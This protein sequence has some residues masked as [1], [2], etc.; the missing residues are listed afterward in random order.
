MSNAIDRL[1][2][3]TNLD[4]SERA[5]AR[6]RFTQWILIAI[7]A[8]LV[9]TWV[10]GVIYAYRQPMIRQVAIENERIVGE[11]ELCPGDKLLIR[12]DFEA[13]SAGKLVQDDTLWLVTPP[14]RL[15]ASTTRAFL[16]DSAMT[17]ELTEAWVIPQMYVDLATAEV[18]PL[19]AGT[20][21]RLFAISSP[22]RASVFDVGSV[23]FTIREGCAP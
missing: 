6:A 14:R 10:W 21:K 2:D 23:N 18:V 16:M 3:S 4:A 19:P 7:L 13:D 12:F 15:I 8:I 9:G 11:S 1:L 20:Y 5:E 17:Q 22:A